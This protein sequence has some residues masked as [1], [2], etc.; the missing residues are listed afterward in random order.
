MHAYMYREKDGRIDR[1][2]NGKAVGPNSG[3]LKV[4]CWSFGGILGAYLGGFAAL[5]PSL[6]GN[7]ELSV[8]SLGHD[9]NSRA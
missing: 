3:H 8:C 1:L 9:S 7:H 4:G 6:I 2:C 5:D